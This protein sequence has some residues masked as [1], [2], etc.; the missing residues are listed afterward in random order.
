MFCLSFEGGDPSDLYRLLWYGWMDISRTMIENC[1]NDAAWVWPYNLGTKLRGRR[2][3]GKLTN[4]RQRGHRVEIRKKEVSY[5]WLSTS[6]TFYSNECTWCVSLWVNSGRES[7]TKWNSSG[8]M[9]WQQFAAM[10]NAFRW[11]LM[12]KNSRYRRQS[13]SPPWEGW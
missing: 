7:A 12:L 8:V 9:L 5:S 6:S 11:A 1:V 3:K 10:A 13:A 2:I 4:A